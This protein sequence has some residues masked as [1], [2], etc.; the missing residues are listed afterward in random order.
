MTVKTSMRA[1]QSESSDE[2][3]LVHVFVQQMLVTRIFAATYTGRNYVHPLKDYRDMVQVNEEEKDLIRDLEIVK[4]RINSVYK[5]AMWAAITGPDD[6]DSDATAGVCVWTRLQEVAFGSYWFMIQQVS[7]SALGELVLNLKVVRKYEPETISTPNILD[8]SMDWEEIKTN[9]LINL[10][11]WGAFLLQ[12]IQE[13][14]TMHNI[15]ETFR[16]LFLLAMTLGTGLMNGLQFLGDYSIKFFREFN[17]FIRVMTPIFLALIDMLSKTIG[18]FYLL[19]VMLW[20][21]GQQGPPPQF[22]ALM[23]ASQ[24][25]FHTGYQKRPPPPGY[26]RYHDY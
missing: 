13:L 21:G 15:K 2:E 1:Q 3:S 17:N 11:V 4:K 26:R 6:S 9:L 20:R 7:F 22:P 8:S 18:G 24:R 14:V 12:G 16:F 10:K 25:N 19:I 5:G 23:A